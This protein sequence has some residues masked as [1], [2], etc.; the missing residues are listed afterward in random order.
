MQWGA[1]DTR[2]AKRELSYADRM[3]M[4]GGGGRAVTN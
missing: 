2:R 3:I 4:Q 1:W